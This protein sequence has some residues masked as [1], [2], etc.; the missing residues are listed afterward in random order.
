MPAERE[1]LLFEIETTSSGKSK[2]VKKIERECSVAKAARLLQVSNIQ[3][4]RMWA[5]G[6]LR[7]WKPGLA[8]AKKK[9]NDGRS[10]KLVLD[11][12]SVIEFRE[13]ERK[14]QELLR[15]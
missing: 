1:L 11:W 4:R 3:V 8:M 14:A 2:V 10:C 6:I 9:G 5:A 15:N 13:V 7:G 12:D